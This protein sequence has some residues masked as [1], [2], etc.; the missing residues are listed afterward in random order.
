MPDGSPWPRVSIVTPSYNQGQFIEETIRSV[1]LQRYPDLEYIIIDGGSA[2]DSIDIIKRYEPWLTW[3]SEKDRGQSDAINKGFLK[4]TGV[5]I[6]WLNSDDFLA[7]GALRAV[8]EAFGEASEA[9]GAIAGVGH[10]IDESYRSFYAPLPQRIDRDTLF[11]AAYGWNFMQPACFMRRKAWEACGPIR[12]DL[13]YCMDLALWLDISL[14]FKFL[15]LPVDIAFCHAH[16]AAKSVADRRQLFAEVAVLL[17]SKPDGFGAA[18][19]V[20]M[21]LAADKLIPNE[22]SGRQLIRLLLRRLLHRMKNLKH[23]SG[24]TAS[25]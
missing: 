1:L 17:A 6:N 14:K 5:L 24:G 22:P 16:P 3:V 21:D 11:E 15:T 23:A 13:H 12:S 25:S 4:T 10:K 20:A 19:R 8:A 7:L 9:V 18:R 2:D